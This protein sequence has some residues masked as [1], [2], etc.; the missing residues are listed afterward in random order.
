MS[1]IWGRK[2]TRREIGAGLAR[3]ALLLPIARVAAACKDNEPKESALRL[4]QQRLLDAFTLLSPTFQTQ[5]SFNTHPHLKLSQTSQASSGQ[6]SELFGSA[7]LDSF[8]HADPDNSAI[9]AHIDK[10]K[11][12]EPF[13]FSN[14]QVRTLTNT[15]TNKNESSRIVFEFSSLDDTHTLSDLMRLLTQYANIPTA[16]GGWVTGVPGVHNEQTRYMAGVYP[17]GKPFRGNVYFGNGIDTSNITLDKL[18]KIS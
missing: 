5:A 8:S 3:S 1:E 18:N 9:T 12:V 4:E 16:H 6:L 11:F 10:W 14:F 13:P 17:D 2:F 7:R 15:K